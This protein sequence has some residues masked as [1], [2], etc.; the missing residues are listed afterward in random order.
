M[1]DAATGF[2]GITERVGCQRYADYSNR[3]L[4][5]CSYG[6]TQLGTG[7]APLVRCKKWVRRVA[8]CRLRDH[9]THESLPR[10]RGIMETPYGLEQRLF[11][12]VSDLFGLSTTVTLYA[13]TNTYF[14]GAATTNGKAKRGRS[15]EKRKDCPLVTLGLV[16]DGVVE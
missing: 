9:A 15:K 11:E 3:R 13:L 10:F 14:E 2:Y 5:H 1:V 12:R 16:L 6:S 4:T 7:R 8:G